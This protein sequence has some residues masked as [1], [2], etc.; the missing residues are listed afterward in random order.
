MSR[1]SPIPDSVRQDVASLVIDAAY[2][3]VTFYPDQ[4]SFSR[5]VITRT[6]QAAVDRY[7]DVPTNAERVR[8]IVLA[9]FEWMDADLVATV[10]DRIDRAGLYG[11][12]DLDLKPFLE[13][14]FLL[15][16]IASVEFDATD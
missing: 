10:V 7:P 1:R 8:R 16:A 6:R 14:F 5:E 12:R 3:D 13:A 2:R 9:E 4:E 11:E 15:Y